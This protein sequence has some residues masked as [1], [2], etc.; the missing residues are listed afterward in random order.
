MTWTPNRYC[1]KL[2]SLPS[3]ESQAVLFSHHRTVSRRFHTWISPPILVTGR[4]S[5][6]G[7]V[8][9]AT[10][11]GSG[12]LSG[13]DSRKEASK[14][15]SGRPSRDREG[16]KPPEARGVRWAVC[17]RPRPPVVCKLVG[18]RGQHTSMGAHR[19]PSCGVKRKTSPLEGVGDG[20]SPR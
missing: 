5:P 10:H 13:T 4:E 18:M 11:P 17:P 1:P 9:A 12:P 16:S 3:A 14:H 19:T 2:P 8:W 6:A 15:H 7:L 20:D